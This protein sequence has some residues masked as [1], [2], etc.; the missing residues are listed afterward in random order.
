MNRGLFHSSH[1]NISADVLLK[2]NLEDRSST[3]ARLS[4]AVGGADDSFSPT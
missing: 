2:P 1:G 4:T 3:R